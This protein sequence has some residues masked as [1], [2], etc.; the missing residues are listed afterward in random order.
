MGTVREM[1]RS[2]GSVQQVV[3]TGRACRLVRDPARFVSG[4]IGGR[5]AGY[6]L[7]AGPTVHVRHRSRDINILNEIFG[8]S[9]YQPPAACDLSGPLRI[10]DLGANIGLFAAWALQRFDVAS[11]VSYE[12]DPDN[13]RLLN[14]TRAQ[15]TAQDRWTVVAAAV[16]DH[17]GTLRMTGCYSEARAVQPGEAGIEVA[18][19]DA[20][21]LG[22][23]DL[24]KVDIEGS[25]WPLLT[26]ARLADLGRVVVIEWHRLACPFPD[27]HQTCRNLL[28]AAGYTQQL[29]LPEAHGA[30]GVVWAWR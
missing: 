16:S 27:P 17:A 29:D 15:H 2:R 8:L 13:L 28:A 3:Q 30:N 1:V 26:D 20:L 4:Q 12:P 23:V 19:I 25:E 10:L 18:M 9:S 7:R 22:P 5:T 11:I 6:T 24:V 14:A 21:E